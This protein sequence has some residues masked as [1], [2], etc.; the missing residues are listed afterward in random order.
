MQQNKYYSPKKNISINIIGA[1]GIINDAHLPAY[2]IAGYPVAGIYD[3]NKEKAT[4]LAT[5]FNIK[6]V[7]NSL[8]EMIAN[9]NELTIFD[10]ALPATAIM[11]VLKQLPNKSAVLIQKPMGNSYAEAKEILGLTQRKQMLAAINFQLRYAPFIEAARNIVKEGSVGE[12]CDIEVHV[13]VHT[14]WN[15]WTFMHG[16]PRI[17]ILYHSIHYVDLIRSFLGNP[18]SMYA[19]TVKHPTMNELASVRTSI[20]MDYGDMVRANILTNHCHQFGFQNQQSYIK[21]EGTKGAIKINMGVLIDYPRGVPDKFEYVIMEDGK[22]PQWKTLEV[23]GGWFPHAFIGSMAEL[24]KATDGIIETPNNSVEDCI[25]T[26]ACV[27]AAY[28][29]SEKGGVKLSEIN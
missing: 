9:S 13:N 1:G 26:M 23:D 27:E 7:Y 24:M 2:E 16:M 20:I 22:Q 3:I 5:K 14:P 6:H 19:K 28:G 29:S 15:L 12:L 18:A 25:H 17:E 11:D 4:A 8:D 21:F 10:I